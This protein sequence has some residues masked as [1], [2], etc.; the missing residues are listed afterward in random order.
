MFLLRQRD[1][2]VIDYRIERLRVVTVAV[3][4]NSFLGSR[5]IDQSQVEVVRIVGRLAKLVYSSCAVCKR[6]VISKKT[7]QKML[8]EKYKNFMLVAN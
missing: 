2:L 5:A 7:F 8:G 4:T 1:V 3:T 6:H